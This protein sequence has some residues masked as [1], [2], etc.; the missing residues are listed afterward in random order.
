MRYMRNAYISV[1][2]S[3]EGNRPLVRPRNIWEDI[4]M[5]LREVGCEAVDWI[6]LA[7]DRDHWWALVD[8]VMN[9]HVP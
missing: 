8:T 3:E 6:H 1:E 2:K 4:R 9:L 5:D 7:R